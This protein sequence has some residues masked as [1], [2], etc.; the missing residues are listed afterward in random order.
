M[1]ASAA[2][3]RGQ[4]FSMDGTL[5]RRA[6]VR[7]V[8]QDGRGGNM[9]STDAQGRFEIRDLPAGRYTVSATKAGYIT[10]QFGQRRADQVQRG[11]ILDV[12]DGQTVER[13]LFALPRGGVITGRLFDEFGEPIAGA[14]V[15]AQRNR[16]IG[17]AHRMV[18]AGSDTTDDQG[19]Y[20]IFGLAPGEYYVSANVRSQ[21]MLSPLDT[22]GEVE[23]FAPSYYPGTP[24]VAEAHRVSVKGG[25]ELSG[26]NFALLS[27]R[28]ARVRGRIMT[29]G[30]EAPPAPMTVQL[31]ARE[32]ST[33]SMLG[34]FAQAKADGS[35]RLT[36]VAP[37][38]YHILARPMGMPHPQQEFAVGQL[39]VGNEDVDNVVLVLARGAV[40]RGVITTDEGVALPAGPGAV[41][42]FVTPAEMDRRPMGPGAMPT[43]NEDWSFEATGLYDRG[44]IRATLPDSGDWFLKGVYHRGV[45]RRIERSA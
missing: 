17:G 9:A 36:G 18:P 34:G 32:L 14:T 2:M 38:T 21:M 26:I 6:L 27:A 8:A 24:N 30:G 44:Y 31:L 28:L 43:V 29:S 25:Q 20:R 45:G 3:L 37:G 4:V 40:L 19:S 5:L 7:A 41:R 15:F 35:F 16:F 13:I 42:L 22:T 1:L 11:T 12:A 23:G 33:M 10:M 39:T